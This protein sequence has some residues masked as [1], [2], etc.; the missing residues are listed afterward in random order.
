MQ[1]NTIIVDDEP[2]AINVISS[3]CAKHPFHF[4][5]LETCTQINQA[6][7]SISI[8]SP[9]LLILDIQLSNGLGFD[10]LKAFPSPTFHTVFVSAFDQYA[11][12][13]IKHH[14]FDYLLKPLDADEF[15]VAINTLAKH[16]DQKPAAF[17]GLERLI[18]STKNHRIGLPTS[19]GVDYYDMRDIVRL[20]ADGSYTQV[21]LGSQQ[22]I[23]VCRRLK[24]FES[25]LSSRSFLR[26]H[27]AH[28]VNLDHIGGLKR[29]DGR[30]LLMKNGD[31]VPIARNEQNKVLE[32]LK[33]FAMHL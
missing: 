14:A 17:N 6:I 21:S 28:M 29:S 31:E 1:I 13:A 25:V 33:G 5:I 23:T 4:N 30:N 3:L 20:Q 24:D 10:I 19:F 32:A 22:R 8:H 9:Q 12:R 27:R 11:M 16:L 7:E 15:N 26:V 2:D 18:N